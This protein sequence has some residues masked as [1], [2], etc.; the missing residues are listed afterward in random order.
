MIKQSLKKRKFRIFFSLISN[1]EKE[2]SIEIF[3][4]NCID[5][6][7]GE[8]AASWIINEGET[9]EGASS[10]KKDSSVIKAEK[11]G[12]I[13]RIINKGAPVKKDSIISK[14]EKTSSIADHQKGSSI[15]YQKG[16]KRQ[17]QRSGNII[18]WNFIEY[19]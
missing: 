6:D 8:E 2:T 17:Q 16:F 13:S 3:F 1:M 7:K 4:K 19:H 9:T 12:A 14:A 11:T 15:E 5:I 10:I 18:K